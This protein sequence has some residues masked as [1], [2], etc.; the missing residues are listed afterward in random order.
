MVFLVLLFVG[1]AAV[2]NRALKNRPRARR[3]KTSHKSKIALTQSGHVEVEGFAWPIHEPVATL[4]EGQ[5]VYYTIKLQQ[6][7][8]RG[9]G[10]DRREEWLT[11]WA[12]SHR[13]P[14]F[15]VDGTGVAILR[16]EGAEVDIAS[17]KTTP[18]NRV[19]K[20]DQEN[21]V[22]HMLDVNVPN[23]P[24]ARSLK[25]FVVPSDFR[26]IEE[27]I[28]VGAPLDVMGAFDAKAAPFDMPAVLKHFVSQVYD[29]STKTI[30]DNTGLLK[31]NKESQ[32]IEGEF[33]NG[34]VLAAKKAARML[35]RSEPSGF[36]EYK[37][38]GEIRASGEAHFLIADRYDE[39]LL[40]K[41]DRYYWPQLA[42]GGLAV[43][44][45]MIWAFATI[46]P[47]VQ[48]QSEE[49]QKRVMTQAKEDSEKNK[50][51]PQEVKRRNWRR[52][53]AR[54]DRQ[55]F[56]MQAEEIPSTS[57]ELNEPAEG[58]PLPLALTYGVFLIQPGDLKVVRYDDDLR[59]V[60]ETPGLLYMSKDG[61]VVVQ[62]LNKR[63]VVLDIVN[64]TRTPYPFQ[65]VAAI[66]EGGE[67]YWMR[68]END[69]ARVYKTRIRDFETVELGTNLSFPPQSTAEFIRVSDKIHLLTRN[70]VGKVTSQFEILVNEITSDVL[71]EI[72]GA[73]LASDELKDKSCPQCLSKNEAITAKLSAVGQINVVYEIY[74]KRIFWIG[75]E[76][77]SRLI[78]SAGPP[79][80]ERLSG[81]DCLR[82][83]QRCL[84]LEASDRLEYFGNYGREYWAQQSQNLHYL[85]MGA[86]GRACEAM[87]FALDGK[88]VSPA[89]REQYLWA[90]CR[91]ANAFSCQELIRRNVPYKGWAEFAMGNFMAF[92]KRLPAN[93]AEG[94]DLVDESKKNDAQ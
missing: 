65:A 25:D 28:L 57:F 94:V 59:G 34:Y 83:P 76:K 62:D 53:M 58:A 45:S 51:T 66:V 64:R 73:I 5:A 29:S 80:E 19:S 81:T 42:G 71:P 79:N 91:T 12:R 86:G 69:L 36:A 50:P 60:G 4:R 27:E 32:K 18:W 93:S 49:T 13:D 30:L 61:Q 39:E 41:P 70:T 24:P 37:I 20:D 68:V 87:L 74:S 2:I 63:L 7:V 38:C 75:N 35:N 33:R 72:E 40:N 6:K 82:Q 78:S 21:F 9:T 55:A 31:I 11:C 90:S 88:Q 54:L 1:G 48:A 43:A 3:M 85:C 14:F 92:E 22:S 89:V 10:S 17:S 56:G 23:F 84:S 16:P 26:I 44:V 46:T 67:L 77:K 47:W 8:R 52:Q 15:V